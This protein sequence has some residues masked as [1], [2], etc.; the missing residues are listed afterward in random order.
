MLT[1]LLAFGARGAVTAVQC[2]R[3][4]TIPYRNSFILFVPLFHVTGLVP[5][6]LGCSRPATS[7]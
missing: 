5:V 1:A 7:W 4:E 6:M 2:R 3:T